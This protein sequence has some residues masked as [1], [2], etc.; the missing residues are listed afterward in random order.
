M[1]IYILL[2]IIGL[3]LIYTLAAYNSFV[4][5]RNRVD[6]AFA[7]M[8]VYLKKRWDLIPNIVESVKGYARHENQVLKEITDLRNRNA[9]YTQ[10]SSDDKALINSKLSQAVGGLMALAEAYPDLKAS[11]N[12]KDLSHQLSAIEEDIANAR[13]YYNATVRIINDKVETFPG[14]IIA[15]LFGFKTMNMFEA[16][17]DEREHIKIKL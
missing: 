16:N 4:K 15:A 3:L 6:E 5:C 10:I 11:D 8:D 2:G 14:N 1:W 7:T 17:Q 9:S 12:F 13:K